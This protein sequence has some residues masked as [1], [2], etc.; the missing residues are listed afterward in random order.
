[1]CPAIFN[2]DDELAENLLGDSFMMDFLKDAMDSGDSEQVMQAVLKI[3]I[4][5]DPREKV[6]RDIGKDLPE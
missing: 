5:R 6:I 2:F 4:A 1:M 3:A